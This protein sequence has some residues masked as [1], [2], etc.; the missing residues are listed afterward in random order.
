MAEE[1]GKTDIWKILGTVAPLILLIWAWSSY[2]ATGGGKD[3]ISRYR[4]GEDALWMFASAFLVYFSYQLMTTYKGGALEKG[5]LAFMAAFFIIF[6]W[7]FIGV[8]MRLHGLG[9]TNAPALDEF[10]EIL[11]GLSG[12]A[13]GIAFLVMYNQLKLKE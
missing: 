5:F 4:I 6:L 9:S 1:T 7:K 2:A 13:I 12:L 10:K 8:V 11:E 3:V